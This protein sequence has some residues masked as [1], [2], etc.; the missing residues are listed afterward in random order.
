MNGAG[1]REQNGDYTYGRLCVVATEPHWFI[2]QRKLGEK[3]F[4]PREESL[5]FHRLSDKT[6]FPFPKTGLATSAV[7]FMYEEKKLI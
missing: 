4:F 3:S 5:A 1:F 7:L 6:A 2:R